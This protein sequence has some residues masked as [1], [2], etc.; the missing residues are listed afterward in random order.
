MSREM[1]TS[2][3]SYSIITTART[4]GDFFY[5]ERGISFDNRFGAHSLSMEDLICIAE[6]AKYAL[7]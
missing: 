3:E 7:V 2:K 5:L 4:P 1:N 6:I